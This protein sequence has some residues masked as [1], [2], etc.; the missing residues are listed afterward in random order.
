MTNRTATRELLVDLIFNKPSINLNSSPIFITLQDSSYQSGLP[1]LRQIIHQTEITQNAILL[2]TLSYDPNGFIEKPKAHLRTLDLSLSPEI[3][4]WPLSDDQPSEPAITSQTVLKLAQ[5]ELKNIPPTQNSI[6]III[7]SVTECVRRWKIRETLKLFNQLL[8]TLS[9]LPTRLIVLE[10]PQLYPPRSQSDP[11]NPSIALRSSS[12]ISNTVT[13]L[14][15]TIYPTLLLDHLINVLGI[16]PP[17]MIDTGTVYDSRL[18][19]LLFELDQSLLNPF[20]SNG[21]GLISQ[22]LLVNGHGTCLISYIT[23]NVSK[24]FNTLASVSVLNVNRSRSS[25]HQQSRL[26][27]LE[28]LKFDQGR[29]IPVPVNS[30]VVKKTRI[31]RDLKTQPKDDWEKSM[32]FKLSLTDQQR[33]DRE[34][35]ALPYLPKRALDGSVIEAPGEIYDGPKVKE[36]LIVYEPDSADDMDDEEPDDEL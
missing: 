5:A 11:I 27:G 24:P 1:I 21:L 20:D 8:T 4:D 18:F 28:G 26:R 25:Q 3:D 13:Q 23:K 6:T 22:S 36:G 34:A 30:I 35:V 17:L 10:S 33:A 15:L 2:I 31:L 32:T 19:S 9:S 7:D 29:L 16:S 14:H 12:F